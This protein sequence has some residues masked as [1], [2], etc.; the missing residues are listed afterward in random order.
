MYNLSDKTKN[1]LLPLIKSKNFEQI[2]KLIHSLDPIE[3]ENSFIINLLGVSKLAKKNKKT[4]AKDTSDA[5]KLFIK[6]YLLDKKFLDSLYN[7][8]ETSIKN[9]SYAESY[10]HLNEH[11]NKIGYDFKAYL[12][13]AR[14]N[15][16]LGNVDD[17]IKLYKK[18]VEKK[19][20][21]RF[22]WIDLI[23]NY[24]YSTSYNSKHYL[25]LCNQYIDTIQKISS[26]DLLEINK[27]KNKNLRIGFYSS[28]LKDHAV[29]K[30]LLENIK[31]LKTQ[32]IEVIAFN[33][34][35]LQDS[36]TKGLKE[37]FSEWYDLFGIKNVDAVN[38]IRNKKIDILFDLVG[39][40]EGSKL[41][42]FKYRSA[43]KQV[44]W[45]G[46]TNTTG[47]IEMDYIISDPHVLENNKYYSEKILKLPEI[48][49]CHMPIGEDIKVEDIPAHKNKTITFGSFNNFA[50]ISDLTISIWSEV[51]KKIDSKLILKTSRSDLE[52]SKSTLLNKFSK[53]GVDIT[54][55]TV[56]NRIDNYQDHLRQYNNID[57][58]LDTFPYNGA[59]TSFESVWM[60]VPVLTIKGNSFVSRYGYSI[61]KNLGLDGFI[62]EDRKDFVSKALNITS[63]LEQLSSIRKKLRPM[64]L[65]SPLFDVTKFNKYF[66]EAIEQILQK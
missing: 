61:N 15:F 23:Y 28:S 64:A 44:A 66:L 4:L 65:V 38:L 51:L 54:R 20:A 16:N 33:N 31:M 5:Q 19:D 58:S 50:K 24:N 36:V 49:S 47:L 26:K 8:G 46:Y 34:T 1:Q 14:I 45:I 12:L 60:G 37:I 57:I 59:T 53:Q 32:G 48:W 63:N 22:V 27:E 41:E 13:L 2:E 25:D 39:Y 10:K 35:G 40:S 30:F 6:A 43:P 17:S 9:K 55:V 7:L 62:A 29:T 18:I 42:L 56:L 3:K 21:T 52:S 11:I